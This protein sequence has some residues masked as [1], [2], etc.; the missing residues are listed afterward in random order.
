MSAA[1]PV[2]RRI[3]TE[4]GQ[5]IVEEPMLASSYHAAVLDHPGLREAL[6]F[7]LASRLEN[8]A[9]SS[10]LIHRLVTAAWDGDPRIGA[11]VRADIQ[12]WCERDPACDQYLMPLMCFKGF[13]AL[14]CHRV[15][16][17]LWRGGRR[18]LALLLHNR[19][20]SAYD[21]DIHP[22]AR[23]G[24]GIMLDHGTG[25]VIGETAV[26]GD[27]VSMLHA[28]T[29]GGSGTQGTERH[30]KI[31]S[32]VLISAGAKVLGPV[33]VGEGA[34]IGAC[35]VVLEDVPPHT[36]VAGVPARAVGRPRSARPAV[37]M[38]QNFAYDNDA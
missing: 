31:D 38:D 6:A 22:G 28:V 15:S 20:A 36:T 17:F 19:V 14:Q 5:A 26:V 21:I 33:H 1:D 4:A 2:W 7:V 34:R 13:H 37:E 35:S 9:V 24:E 27:C 10:L 3:C 23:I 18:W 12:A 30:P 32:G 29:L 11:A 8:R 16:H 25:L